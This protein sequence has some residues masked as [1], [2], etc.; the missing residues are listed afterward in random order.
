MIRMKFYVG[1]S[2]RADRSLGEFKTMQEAL[3][4]INEK[5]NETREQLYVYQL[6]ENRE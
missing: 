1:T 6:P 2:R 5:K 4:F 3:D